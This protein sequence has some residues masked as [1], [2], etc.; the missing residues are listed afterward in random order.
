MKISDVAYWVNFHTLKI[1]SSA[2][3]DNEN[4]AE[5]DRLTIVDEFEKNHFGPLPRA[6]NSNQTESFQCKL[7]FLVPRLRSCRVVRVTGFLRSGTEHFS[8][9]ISDYGSHL[10]ISS[11]FL[12][13]GLCR[14]KIRKIISFP[15]IS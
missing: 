12:P 11:K 7:Y 5:N 2:E 8:K 15:Y 9:C 3:S 14:Q 4:S 6:E 1:E 10:E 13:V